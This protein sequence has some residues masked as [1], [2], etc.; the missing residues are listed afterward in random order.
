L[1]LELLVEVV[2]GS[3]CPTRKTIVTLSTEFDRVNTFDQ[4]RCITEYCYFWLRVV[5]CLSPFFPL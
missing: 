2:R 3:P 1:T 4:A 5:H